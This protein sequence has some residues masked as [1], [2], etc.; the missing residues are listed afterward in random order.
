LSLEQ[1]TDICGRILPDYSVD[2]CYLFGS[3]AKGTASEQSDVDLLVSMPV[4]G[5]KFFELLERLREG[6]KKKVDLLDTA[7]LRNNETLVQEI[8][9]DGI[10]I[11]G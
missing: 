9:K 11:Y 3:Y 6:L 8:L 4:D 1:I 2:Y 5:L 7:Q 10:K